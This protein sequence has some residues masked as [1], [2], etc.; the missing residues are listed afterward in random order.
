MVRS[1]VPIKYELRKYSVWSYGVL[2]TEHLEYN[3]GEFPN[4]E[5]I[6]P[7]PTFGIF[8]S[9]LSLNRWDLPSCTL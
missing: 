9:G 6:L 3:C 5:H 8:R 4:E 1:E 2:F 7:P